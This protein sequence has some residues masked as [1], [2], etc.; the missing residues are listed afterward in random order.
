MYRRILFLLVVLCGCASSVWAQGT[1]QSGQAIGTN[2]RPI[3]G[4]TITVCPTS[5]TGIPCSPTSTIYTDDTLTTPA[6]NPFQADGFGNYHFSA[7]AGQYI[8]TVSNSGIVGY[9]YRIDLACMPN[10]SASGCGGGGGG[11]G[12]AFTFTQVAYSATPTFTMTGANNAFQM[13]LG[14]NVTSSTVAGTF[15]AGAVATFDIINPSTNTFVWPTSFTNPPTLVSGARGTSHTDAFCVYDGSG[16][17]CLPSGTVTNVGA[18]SFSPDQIVISSGLANN[19]IT[20]QANLTYLPGDGTVEESGGFRM[21]GPTYDC[22]GS[23]G[24]TGQVPTNLG[25]GFNCWQWE[26]P[27]GGGGSPGGSLNQMQFNG[28]GPAFA[29]SSTLLDNGSKGVA[30]KGPQPWSDVTAFGALGKGGVNAGVT[31]AISASSST[32]TLS[33]QPTPAFTV[34]TGIAITGAGANGDLLIAGV[35]SVSGTTVGLSTTAQ[36]GVSGAAVSY[37]DT[38]PIQLGINSMC[39]NGGA[40][41]FP[42]T[43]GSDY[44]V[45]APAQ[46]T[47]STSS[48]TSNVVTL[49]LATPLPSQVITSYYAVVANDSL[50][51]ANGTFPVTVVDSTHVTYPSLSANGTGTAGTIS[52]PAL[53]VNTNCFQFYLTGGNDLN[54]T[55]TQFSRPPKTVIYQSTTNTLAPPFILQGTLVRTASIEHMVIAAQNQAV[56]LLSGAGFNFNDTCLAVG[57]SSNPSGATADNTPLAIYNT[58]WVRMKD[59]CLTINSGG[60]STQFASV[61]ATVGNLPQPT[62]FGLTKFEDVIASGGSFL[63]DNR[64]GGGVNGGGNFIWDNTQ[65]ENSSASF[66]TITNTSGTTFP[67]IGPVYINNGAAY[68]CS[69]GQPFINLNSSTTFLGPVFIYQPTQCA[70]GAGAPIQVT[71]GHIDNIH[72]FAADGN[73]LDSNGN[74]VGPSISENSNGLDFVGVSNTNSQNTYMGLKTSGGAF[75]L[76]KTGDIQATEAFDPYFGWGMGPGGSVTCTGTGSA[77]CGGYDSQITR[78]SSENINIEYA[79]ALPPTNF[80]ATPT[81][82]GSLAAGTYYEAIETAGPVGSTYSN[83]SWVGP[84]VLSGPNNAIALTWTAP[85]GTNPQGCNILRGT[86]LNF[87][88]VPYN[89]IV[90]C[91]S[92][93]SYTDTGGAAGTGSAVT[94]NQT[95]APF[96]RFPANNTNASG[97][98]VPYYSTGSTPTAGNC[99]KWG[100]AGQLA[101]ALGQCNS[102]ILTSFATAP[103]QQGAAAAPT[104]NNAINIVKFLLPE[105]LTFSH[106]VIDV[107]LADTTGGDLFDVGIYDP[108]GTLHCDAGPVA[109]GSTGIVDLPCVQGSMTLAAHYY[110]LAF[111][112]NYTGTPAQIYFGGAGAGAGGWTG[113]SSNTSAT[114]STAGQLPGTITITTAG[115][116]ISS[117][118]ANAFIYLH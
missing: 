3:N 100:S 11:G 71:A 48:L 29:G 68:D 83:Y 98:N 93:T 8:V 110:Y 16:W 101:D 61:M 117:T 72:I 115:N 30:H 111:T 44:M 1:T 32:L 7:A 52:F 104:A 94:A 103:N 10:A 112:G 116:S 47:I 107:S 95:V 76:G 13:T 87:T 58:F 5:A 9:S 38:Y 92:T 108:S 19:D 85:G 75:R 45:R 70:A 17:N 12:G 35:T 97:G 102:T 90:N 6:A 41:N 105:N 50:A 33:A 57:Y 22:T 28:A 65:T 36:T 63:I 59:G 74:L 88:S 43:I 49:T 81:T 37:D 113:Q 114:T 21:L 89:V 27:T 99:V 91:V 25:S 14:G 96:Y 84:I 34:G 77:Y 64:A 62:N 106:I 53:Q 24:A 69:F 56:Q 86:G 46:I 18:N 54:A 118:Y 20:T 31:G 60:H 51:G 4:V 2:G 67:Q 109:L 40:L 82:G 55:G 79:A 15:V 78:A 23:A 66:L 26:T 73:V 42:P 39:S 80:A